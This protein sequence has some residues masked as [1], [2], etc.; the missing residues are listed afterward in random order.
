[1]RFTSVTGHLKEVC[2]GDDETVPC[3]L[4]FV[5]PYTKKWSS[6]LPVD[7][8]ELPVEKTVKEV[9]VM[10]VTAMLYSDKQGYQAAVG[11]GG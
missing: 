7:L 3:Q 8:F 9:W 10:M 11:A 1:M 6:C 2:D 4:D 5:E